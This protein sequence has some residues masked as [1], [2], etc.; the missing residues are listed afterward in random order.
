[1]SRI[2]VLCVDRDD[3]LGRKAGVDSPVIGRDENIEAAVKLA[4]S[5]PEDS[6]I[7]TI[8]G[9]VKL[10]DELV[11]EGR[12]VEIVTIAGDINVGSVSDFRIAEQLDAIKRR[13]KAR[14]VVVV[15]DG[16][17]D[18]AILPIIQSRFRV[19]MVKRIVVKQSR[20]IEN[21]YYMIKQILNDPKFSRIIFI[22]LGVASLVYAISVFVNYPQGAS[23]AILSFLGFFFLMKGFGLESIVEEFTASLKSTLYEGKV[24]FVTNFIALIMFIIAIVQGFGLLW[25]FYTSPIQVGYLMLLTAFIYGA[26]WWFVG[27]GIFI[28]LGKFLDGYLENRLHSRYIV[29]PFFILAMGL[30]I[31]GGSI[32]ILS[33]HEGFEISRDSAPI[34]LAGA[35]SGAIVISLI[36]IAISSRI[37]K[38]SVHGTGDKTP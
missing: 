24:S 7:N 32:F 10:Y 4:Q 5:D 17:E 14:E 35:I 34:Y 21:T 16:A 20:D 6:D 8:F 15:T 19:N 23:I 29:Y 36:S 13:L 2:L 33:Y 31:W 27:A 3:D 22:P 9:A 18:E 1:M 12:D 38:S 25:S 28:G 26:I 37:K 30:I 11:K